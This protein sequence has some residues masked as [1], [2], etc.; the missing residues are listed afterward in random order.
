M[1]GNSF[2]YGTFVRFLH[3]QDLTE[4]NVPNINVIDFRFRIY[5]PSIT[6]F[7]HGCTRHIIDSPNHQLQR[8]VQR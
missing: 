6:C 5:V 1:F 8:Y 3:M 7:E 4:L 2:T